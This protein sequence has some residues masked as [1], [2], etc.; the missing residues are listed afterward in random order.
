M[1]S[2]GRAG[3]NRRKAGLATPDQGA[4]RAAALNAEDPDARAR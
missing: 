2:H 1:G 3:R 4:E